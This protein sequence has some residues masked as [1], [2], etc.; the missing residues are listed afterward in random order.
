MLAKI[1]NDKIKYASDYEVLN[2]GAVSNPTNQLLLE[3]GFKE[4]E[5]I[6]VDEKVINFEETE[7]KIVVYNEKYI[8][9]IINVEV[10]SAKQVRL[11]LLRYNLLNTIEEAIKK[12]SIE[13]QLE[14]EYATIFSI[15]D[16]F[17]QEFCN[18]LGINKEQLQTMFNE[19]SL[20]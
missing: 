5:Y 17:I 8:P 9:T 4:V 2:I 19:A 13:K 1:V 3:N 7:S 6:E 10:I 16:M 11:I 15:N 14:W 20:L 12:E 18:R